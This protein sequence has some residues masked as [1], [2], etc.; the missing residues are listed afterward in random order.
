M[1]QHPLRCRCGTVQGIVENPQRANH[2][3]CYCKDCQAFAR[4]LGNEDRILDAQGGSEIIQVLPKDVTFSQ[5]VD[6]LACLRL[7]DKGMI[8]WYAA[9]CRTPIGNTLEN[10]KV[11]FIGLLHNCLE[12]ADRPLQDSFGPVSTYAYP[13]CAIGAPKPKASGLW[14]TIWW[15]LTTVGK[16]RLNGDYKLTPFFRL[17]TGKPIASPHVLSSEVRSNAMRQPAP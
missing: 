15:F 5:G 2:A 6:S 16:S 11:S 14:M 10:Y 3:V 13:N 17:D 9:C 8:R 12:T 4:Y 7:T 1:M